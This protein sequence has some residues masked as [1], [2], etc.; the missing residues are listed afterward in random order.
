MPNLACLSEPKVFENANK[1]KKCRENANGSRT[2]EANCAPPSLDVSLISIV[3]AK[4]LVLA[5]IL[6][7]HG[8]SSDVS[9][10][11]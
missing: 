4:A 11:S 1:R 7:H 6:R 2:P 8:T 9:S 5:Y 3:P 10:Y